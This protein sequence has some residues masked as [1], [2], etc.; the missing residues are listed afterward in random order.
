MN[1]TNKTNKR[2]FY[3]VFILKLLPIVFLFSEYTYSANEGQKKV[4]A[5][6]TVIAAGDIEWTKHTLWAP[7]YLFLGATNTLE[8]KTEEK[9]GK[10]ALPLPSFPFITTDESKL[11]AKKRG[12]DVDKAGSHHIEAE[13]Y[14]LVFDSEEKRN[15]HPFKRIAQL[16]RTADVAFANLEMS[17]SDAGRSVGSFRAPTSMAK[18]LSWAGFDVL[19]TANNHIFDSGEQGMFDTEQALNENNI[20]SFGTGR[21]LSE[22]RKPHI[23]EKNGIKLAFLGYSQ[24]TNHWGGDFALSNRSGVAPL[25][26]FL[27]AEDIKNIRNSV[28]FVIVSF[29]WGMENTQSIHPD[30]IELAHQVMDAGADVILGHSPHMPQAVEMYKNK[31]I[32]Y[33][34]GNLVFGHNHD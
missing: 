30:I 24:I 1:K 5:S 10:H 32:L 13:Q 23:V 29:H 11:Y 4:D 12:V 20:A 9:Y 25:D 27:V 18:V 21:N 3:G 14:N 33:S 22:A 17:L 2:K 16:L 6:I 19:T 34:L 31:P 28:D 15:Y 26:S 8:D 7:R